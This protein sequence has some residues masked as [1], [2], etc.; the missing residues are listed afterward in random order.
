PGASTRRRRSP[1]GLHRPERDLRQRQPA[2]PG[3][4][5]EELDR[6]LR[7]PAFAA[8]ACQPGGKVE[9]VLETAHL[10]DGES[11]RSGEAAP[12]GLGVV[13]HVRGITERLGALDVL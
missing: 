9:R 5:A 1:L 4:F 2:V 6:T 10:L 12:L 13:A 3:S 8:G 7:V 11:R